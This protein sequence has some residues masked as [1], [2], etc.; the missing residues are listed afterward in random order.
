MKTNVTWRSYF[1]QQLSFLFFMPAVIWPVIFLYIPLLNM[2]LI[3]CMD[4][5]WSMPLLGKYAQLFD[6]THMRIIL[7]SLALGL[8]SS[9]ACLLCAYPAAYF[10]A[11]R[12]TKWKHLLLFLLMIPLWTNFLIQV[13]GWQ[14]I[15]ARHGLVNLFLQKLSIISE[16]L[17]L[18][19]TLYMVFIVMVYCYIPFM[20][21]PLYSALAG[22]DTKLLEAS[23]DL[24]ASP[25]KT[26]LRV[27]LPLSMS[28]IRAGM[29]LTFVLGFGEFAIPALIGGGKY[30]T[31]GMLISYYFLI[32][33]D[34]GLGAAFTCLSGFF[35]LVTASALY[36]C[37]NRWCR[38]YAGLEL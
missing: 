9:A 19:H 35:L 16:P 28:G 6:W 2:M 26:F 29:L 1:T 31:V 25:F 34:S 20:F 13:Y 37:F 32:V 14:F 21:M 23:A 15:I 5:G 24:G 22:F 4:Q 30:M 12:A 3:S 38:K 18:S 36:V 33:G 8:G 27:T 17:A 11:I 10:I 7:R